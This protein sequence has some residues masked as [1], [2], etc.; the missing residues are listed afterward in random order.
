MKRIL[1][2][3]CAL[4][5]AIPALAIERDDCA[6]PLTHLGALYQIRSIMMRRYSS[7][8]DV[9]HFIDQRIEE[10]REPQPGGGYKWVRWVRPSGNGP[11]DKKVHTVVAVHGQGDP[12]MFESSS[13][14]VYA[15]RVVVPSKRSMFKGNNPVYVGDVR[16]NYDRQADVMHINRWMQPDTSQTLELDGIYER[17]MAD[18]QVSVDRRDSK[19][20]V[21]EIHFSQAVAQDDPANPSY[22]TIKA[23]ERI[24]ETPDPATVDAEIAALESSLFPG[25][26]SPPLLTIVR[27]LRRADELLRSEKKDDQDKGDRLLKET[28]RRLR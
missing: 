9:Q 22:S 27:D 16:I 18:A 10:L 4:A 24:R 14:H 19:E 3:C 7:S 17:V 6:G 21:A 15:V 13:N 11:T 1:L 12:D 2:F 23:L 20:A 26:D 5:I 25:S 8:S 28:L